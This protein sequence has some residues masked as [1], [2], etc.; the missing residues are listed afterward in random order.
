MIEGQGK[1]KMCKTERQKGRS[2]KAAGK[3]GKGV[4]LM[5]YKK[6]KK[7]NESQR[8][9]TLI[10]VLIAMAIFSIGILG[11][12]TM[13]LR[14]ANGNT[15]ARIRTEASIWAQDQ[16]ET[17]MQLPFTDPL[18]NVGPHPPITTTNG[19]SIAW[20]VTAGVTANTRIIQVT[21][22]GPRGNRS[23]TV[24]FVRAPVI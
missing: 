24:T 10:E 17:L 21:V 16:V 13:Q 6:D 2:C 7:T 19:H 1:R 9:F 15:S 5:N 20:V 8:G 18:L 11:V 3:E 22:T 4:K 23:S 14:S 12:S